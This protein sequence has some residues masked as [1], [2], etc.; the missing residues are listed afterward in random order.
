MAWAEML[1]AGVRMGLAPD[2]F[3]RLSLREWRMLMAVA[4]AVEPPG[5]AAF[6]QMARQWPDADAALS[7]GEIE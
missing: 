2:V 5:R 1:Q 4:G 6:E 3:W 7:A